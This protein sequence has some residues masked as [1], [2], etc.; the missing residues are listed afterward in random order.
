[1]LPRVGDGL[2]DVIASDEFYEF[3]NVQ[4]EFERAAGFTESCR[5]FGAPSECHCAVSVFE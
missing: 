5:L 2:E 3:L 4:S 1:M